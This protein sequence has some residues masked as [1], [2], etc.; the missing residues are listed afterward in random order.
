MIN[1][2]R[3]YCITDSK[4]EYVISDAID[5]SGVDAVVDTR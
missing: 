3:L 5:Q 1:K 2:Y 4:Y